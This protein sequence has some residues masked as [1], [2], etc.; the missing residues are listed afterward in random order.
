MIG[1]LT[2]KLQSWSLHLYA[3]PYH[4]HQRYS[5]DRGHFKAKSLYKQGSPITWRS[6]SRMRMQKQLIIGD[7]SEIDPLDNESDQYCVYIPFLF[8]D[9]VF[10]RYNRKSFL[11]PMEAI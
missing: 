10:K 5:N 4:E 7:V 11:L 2:S 1:D 6:C 8:R 9:C 3:R